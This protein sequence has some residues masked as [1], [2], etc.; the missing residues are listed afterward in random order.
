MQNASVLYCICTALINFNL[1]SWHRQYLGIDISHNL[2]WETHIN[3]ITKKANQT[4]GFLRRNIK[5][6]SESLRA[7]A[8]K[9]LVRPQLEYGSEVWAPYTQSQIDH[10]ESV[11]RRSARW[12]KHDYGQTSSVTNMLQS[13]NLRRLD[14]R[15]ID[16]RLSLM[17][18]ISHNLVAIPLSEYL[19]PLP[20]SSRYGHPLS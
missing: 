8:Y 7:S 17:Y 13:L 5:V 16:S 1:V 6:K 15:R 20:K 4:L 19:I 14:L 11:Q 10:I 18:K 2:S 9:T 3:R 12:I